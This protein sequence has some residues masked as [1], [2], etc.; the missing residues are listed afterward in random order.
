[1]S[2]EMIMDKT[3]NGFYL[4]PTIC[5]WKERSVFYDLV[6]YESK[7]FVFIWFR[8]RF[9]LREVKVILPKIK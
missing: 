2:V 4:L 5:I 3:N 7:T 6:E 9:G 1:M 8:Y